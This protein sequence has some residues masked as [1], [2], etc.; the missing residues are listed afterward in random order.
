MELKDAIRIIGDVLKAQ[1]LT[2]QEHRV[3]QEAFETIVSKA[4]EK[5]VKAEG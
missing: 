5:E 1:K 3:V 2:L 4:A